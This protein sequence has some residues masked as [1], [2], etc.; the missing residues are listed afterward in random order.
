MS[1]L[2]ILQVFSTF[3]YPMPYLYIC[4]T[5]FFILFMFNVWRFAYIF[6]LLWSS[7]CEFLTF[8]SPQLETIY[9]SLL[10]LSILQFKDRILLST[11][12]FFFFVTLQRGKRQLGGPRFWCPEILLCLSS[13]NSALDVSSSSYQCP[14]RWY[15]PAV[16]SASV[17]VPK[18]YLGL[19][20][21][22]TLF[23][24]TSQDCL[25]TQSS[26]LHIGRS[27]A[28][29]NLF[30]FHSHVFCFNFI[31]WGFTPFLIW[32]LLVNF[33]LVICVCVFFFSNFPSA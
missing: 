20:I 15:T 8:F 33:R 27:F 25:L 22:S 5:I 9:L 10:H 26:H 3:P 30:W 23:S 19:H 7:V 17:G 14:E 11:Y 24:L 28:E 6:C 16:L 21:L 32:L 2:F 18:G 4:Q 12:F 1:Y 13:L 31:T 29:L